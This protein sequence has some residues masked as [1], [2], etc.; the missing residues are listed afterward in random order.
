MI[1]PTLCFL[2]ISRGNFAP[3]CRLARHSSFSLLWGVPVFS[4]CVL[5]RVLA[6]SRCSQFVGTS[7]LDF[8]VAHGANDWCDSLVLFPPLVNVQCSCEVDAASH[9]KHHPGRRVQDVLRLA[10][11]VHVLALRVCYRERKEDIDDSSC[12]WRGGDGSVKGKRRKTTLLWWIG[13]FQLHHQVVCVCVLWLP[14][15]GSNGP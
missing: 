9:R 5:P 10:D 14:G 3:D 15:S 11:D 2:P 12:P 8:R 6:R 1:S 7:I 13:L 4:D